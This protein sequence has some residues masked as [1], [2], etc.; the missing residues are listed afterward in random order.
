MKVPA[1][2]AVDASGAYIWS[3]HDFKWGESGEW[4]GI[5]AGD[6]PLHLC[7]QNAL[8]R[9]N[10]TTTTKAKTTT[11]KASTVDIDRCRSAMEVV[12]RYLYTSDNEK[13]DA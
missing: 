2:P 6:A 7:T 5:A 3:N 4:T 8:D 11:T 12:K 1:T 9:L 13:F 10:P